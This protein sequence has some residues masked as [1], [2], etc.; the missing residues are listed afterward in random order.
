VRWKVSEI[1]EA[2]KSVGHIRHLR[3]KKTK[4]QTVRVEINLVHEE[5]RAF[6]NGDCWLW[7][8]GSKKLSDIK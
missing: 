8:P 2:L 6:R 5:E 1:I 4:Y 7:F 3:T